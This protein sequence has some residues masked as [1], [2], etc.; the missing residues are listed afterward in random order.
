M[1]KYSVNEAE[2]LRQC[3]EYLDIRHA[4]NLGNNAN[5]YVLVCN[6]LLVT[7]SK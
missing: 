5:E 7:T 6:K 2:C 3:N 1:I 4:I